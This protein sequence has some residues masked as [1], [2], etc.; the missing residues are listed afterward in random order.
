M[1]ACKDNGHRSA[2]DVVVVHRRC[3]YSAFN[4]GRRTPSAYSL[5]RCLVCGRMWR[6]KAAYVMRLRD[7][8]GDEATRNVR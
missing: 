1:A 4:G 6:T 5:V 8:A 7:A 3:N 2:T